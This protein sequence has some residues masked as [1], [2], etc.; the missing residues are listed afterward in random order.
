MKIPS[1]E[2]L[3]GLREDKDSGA[4]TLREAVQDPKNRRQ[5]IDDC[6]E[7][8]G[9][10]KDLVRLTAVWALGPENVAATE[11][12]QTWRAVLGDDD[13]APPLRA[14][15]MSLVVSLDEPSEDLFRLTTVFVEVLLETGSLRKAFDVAADAFAERRRLFRKPRRMGQ[16]PS[17]RG[18]NSIR[19]DRLLEMKPYCY[20]S[21]IRPVFEALARH[22]K[23]KAELAAWLVEGAKLW[24]VERES[25]LKGLVELDLVD[26]S[27]SELV[28]S[29]ERSSSKD[30][31]ATLAS[32]LGIAKNDGRL[33]R[34]LLA[35]LSDRP[36]ACERLGHRILNAK[37]GSLILGPWPKAFNGLDALAQEELWERTEA[38]E[39]LVALLAWLALVGAGA[40]SSRSRAVLCRLLAVKWQRRAGELLI[41]AAVH[42]RMYDEQVM[43]AASGREFAKA[44]VFNGRH[45]GEELIAVDGEDVWRMP[46]A[47]IGAWRW[48][49]DYV[50]APFQRIRT[51]VPASEWCND[52]DEVGVLRLSLKPAP[53][54]EVFSLPVSLP[55]QNN[56]VNLAKRQV[57]VDL[58]HRGELLMSVKSPFSGSGWGTRNYLFSFEPHDALWH[59]WFVKDGRLV[60]TAL[61]ESSESEIESLCYGEAIVWDDAGEPRL[62]VDGTHYHLDD[63]QR[64]KEVEDA[65]VRQRRAREAATHPKESKASKKLVAKA[66]AVAGD[67][68]LREA[69][70]WALDEACTLAICQFGS[71]REPEL[72]LLYLVR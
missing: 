46:A 63:W 53:T 66:Q 5:F 33:Y 67:L 19:G 2:L 17:T 70:A 64:T 8:L 62:T 18:A 16:Q 10:E 9:A 45:H 40:R 39:P 27:I 32:V 3:S 43:A 36:R 34:Q 48:V 41:N 59:R 29:V 49:G 31:G 65:L 55:I 60:A 57:S 21:C 12:L 6:S 68:R 47:R 61:T 23:S 72:A 51:L 42:H 30:S 1:S 50:V 35:Q 11:R 52:A 13:A 14:S 44:L 24:S 4:A 56:G 25:A 58:V 71:Y 38:S 28:R 54:L 37:I 15:A 20:R 22:A 26:E 69:Q 7:L